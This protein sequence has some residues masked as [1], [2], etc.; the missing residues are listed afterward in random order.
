MLF[1]AVSVGRR[2]GPAQTIA[3]IGGSGVRRGVRAS[4]LL[5]Q[6]TGL[7]ISESGESELRDGQALRG[8]YF[9]FILID[10]ASA[11]GVDRMDGQRR[12]VVGASAASVLRPLLRRWQLFFTRSRAVVGTAIRLAGGSRSTFGNVS[13]GPVP[14]GTRD[15]RS[16]T[17]SVT[18]LK[19]G[20]SLLADVS[21][22]WDEAE[23]WTS[24]HLVTRILATMCGCPSSC[25]L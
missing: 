4:C 3:R 20:Y 23:G 7:G 18:W 10:P 19:K 14:C 5:D 9:V 12:F 21:V 11:S 13:R 8:T 2:G 22:M 6:T 25:P 17:R 15:E 24:G 1:S 16:V